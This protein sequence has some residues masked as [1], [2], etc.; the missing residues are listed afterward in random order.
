MTLPELRS[1]GSF[2][3]GRAS[4]WLTALVLAASAVNAEPV[5][6]VEQLVVS[7]ASAPGPEGERIGQV[8]SGDKLEL[9]EREGDEAHVRLPSGTEGWIKASYLSAEEPLQ[10]RLTERT[11]EV[12]NLKQE[13]EKLKQDMTRLESQLA[14]ARAAHNVASA[15]SPTPAPTPGPAAAGTPAPNTLPTETIP[16]AVS[17]AISGGSTPIR[18]TVFLRSPDRPGQTPWPL[19]LGTSFVMLLAGFVLGWKTL[20]R[21]IRQKYGGLRIY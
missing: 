8:K 19:V 17:D 9:L 12:E 3:L 1:G 21:R 5:Y 2:A 11:A 15:P 20:D 7:L 16:P 4:L 13:G 10:N 18:E 6:V 14:A